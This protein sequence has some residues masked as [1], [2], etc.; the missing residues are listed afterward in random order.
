MSTDENREANIKTVLKTLQEILPNEN[1]TEGQDVSPEH[2]GNF[3]VRGS[4]EDDSEITVIFYKE[5]KIFQAKQQKQ[6][7]I[8]IQGEKKTKEKLDYLLILI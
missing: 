5:K 6:T 8:S 7:L 3:V 1:R 4:L 2:T